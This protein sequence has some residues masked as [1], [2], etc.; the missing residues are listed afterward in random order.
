MNNIEEFL[1][2][3]KLLEVCVALSE[4]A[5]DI[6]REIWKSGSLQVVE[7]QKDDPLTQA[8]ILAQDFIVKGLR[9]FSKN[10]KIIGEEDNSHE[11]LSVQIP[12]DIKELFVPPNP[13]QLFFEPKLSEFPSYLRKVPI[14]E[15]CM[16][17]DPIDGT[18]EF[19][20]GNT[21]SVFVLIGVSLR[22]KAIMG[23]MHQPFGKIENEKIERG[24]TIFG[25][26]EFGIQG[27]PA[28]PQSTIKTKGEWIVTTSKARLN[29]NLQK[30]VDQLQPKSSIHVGGCA[31]KIFL[32]L[33]G[34]A[35]IYLFFSSQ[36]S[37][38]D[39]CAC[40]PLLVALKGI[41]TDLKGNTYQYFPS[42]PI[43]N[44]GGILACSSL[45]IHQSVLEELKSFDTSYN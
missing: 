27:L 34:R 32:L 45:S 20:S 1:D 13:K 9:T 31:Y 10:V 30:A 3:V 8:D 38:W 15:I 21:E 37:K 36:T 2:L 22:G 35:D 11:L 6:I 7:K 5:G 41:L 12:K 19:T 33:S 28:L 44:Q 43:V 23:V 29:S 39:I 25:G 14:E 42:S 17:V 18:R 40:E 4:Q 26:G 16:F 24:V